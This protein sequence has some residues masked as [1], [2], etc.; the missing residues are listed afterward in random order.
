MVSM[1]FYLGK[2]RS[3]DVVLVGCQSTLHMSTIQAGDEVPAVIIH[4]FTK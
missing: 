4:F 2:D 1:Q 3:Q